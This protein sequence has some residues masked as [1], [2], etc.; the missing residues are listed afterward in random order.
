[1][2]VIARKGCSG[3]T[4]LAVH[5]AIAAHLRGRKVLLADA[6]AQRSALEVLRG[7]QGPGPEVVETAGSKLFALQLSAVRNDVDTMI[8]DTPAVLEDELGHSIVV[9]DLSLL[10]IRPTFLDIAAAL[11]TA[12]VIRRLRKPGLIVL[13]QAPVPREGVEPPAVKRA[14]EAL[15]LMRL[16]VAPLILRA[17]ANYQ[18]VLETGRSVE[19][20]DAANPAAREVAALWGFIER[21]VYGRAAGARTEA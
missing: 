13:N 16:P 21:L 17:R 7:R 20:M 5:L 12:E 1:M 6:D 9:S 10:V 15:R 14:I 3:K 2:A 4:T 8:I 19:E 11:R 18:S